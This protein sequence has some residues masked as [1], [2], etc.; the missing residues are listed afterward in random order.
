MSK[1]IVGIGG[2]MIDVHLIFFKKMDILK[3]ELISDTYFIR[4]KNGD[5]DMTFSI[6]KKEYD[7]VKIDLRDDK[8]NSIIG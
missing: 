3:E 1:Y 5:S 8:I 7:R 6:H 2:E 4:F